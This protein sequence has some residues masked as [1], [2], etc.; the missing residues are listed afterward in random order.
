MAIGPIGA[1]I[2]VNQNMQIQASKQ[3]DFQN[4]L[5]LQNIQA[6]AVANEKDKDVQEVR[7]PEETYK[8]D[9]EHEHERQK[10]EE[11]NGATQEQEKKAK[12]DKKSSVEEENDNGDF[13]H[14]DI[15]I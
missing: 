11:E 10:K 1:H 12:K 3:T 4:K 2:Y 8:I 5:D 13:E 9:P 15:K 7:P 14:L 6:A